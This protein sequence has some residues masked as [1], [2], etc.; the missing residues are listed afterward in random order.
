MYRTKVSMSLFVC[1]IVALASMTNWGRAERST[2]SSMDLYGA[3]GP[4]GPRLREQL[5]IMPSGDPKIPL[6]ATVFKPSDPANSAARRPLVIINHGTDEGT[7]EAVSM[8]VFYWL[9]RWF[10]ERG[11][12]VAVPQ[13][14]GH[15]AT[16]GELVEALDNCAQ[17]NHLRAGEVAADDIEA[18]LNFMQ[19]QTNIDDGNIVIVGI[20]TGGWASLALAARNPSGVRKVIN[21]AGG[22]GAHAG[23]RQGAIC[24]ADR[25]VEASGTLGK[26]ARVPTLWLYSSN[27]SYFGAELSRSMASAW[28][29]QGGLADF[30]LLPPYGTE[31]HNLVDDRAGWRLWGTAV[32][33]FLNGKQRPEMAPLAGTQSADV[34]GL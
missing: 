1:C 31:G 16:G 20:S 10:V 26:R 2:I 30:H 32:S 12:V 17:P 13:R 6:R 27:D 3:F 15:G 22:R 25:L 33:D 24:A 28:N 29:T 34:Q 5:W 4:E 19:R 9:S 7:R 21:F 18:V 8:P 14:R 11:Y 23:G